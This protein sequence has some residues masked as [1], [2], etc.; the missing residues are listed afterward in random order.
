MFLGHPAPKKRPK[1]VW[2]KDNDYSDEHRRIVRALYDAGI[3]YS[4]EALGQ[5]IEGLGEEQL[6][7]TSFLITADHG[8]GFG[9]QGFYL[10]AHHFWQEVIHVPLVAVGPKFKPAV[11]DRLTQ[12]LD[13]TTT[14]LDLAGLIAAVY[15]AARF[16]SLNA[17][18]TSSAS[19]TS[20]VSAGRPSLVSATK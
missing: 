1:V 9:E 18:T 20:L 14:I 6:K 3:R 5:L 17:T 19:T 8:E 2:E 11:D 13:V 7:N 12:S 4:D 16:S 15:P 10:H